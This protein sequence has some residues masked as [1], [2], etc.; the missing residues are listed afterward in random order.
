[1]IYLNQ[2]SAHADALFVPRRLCLGGTSNESYERW[3]GTRPAAYV[4]MPCY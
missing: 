1:M 3:I 2:F 4:I